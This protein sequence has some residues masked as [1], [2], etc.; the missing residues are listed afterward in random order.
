MLLDTLDIFIGLI[1]VFLILSLIVSALGDGVSAAINQKGRIFE[2]SMQVLLGNEMAARF[3]AHEAVMRLRVKGLIWLRRPS[4]VPDVVIAD[5][6]VDLCVNDDANQSQRITVNP[7]SFDHALRGMNSDV[8]CANALKEL[9]QRAGCDLDRMKLLITDW[10]NHTGDRSVSW[11][12]R[13]MGISLF[14][15]GLVAAVSLNADTLY[16]F[17]ILSED[18]ALRQSYVELATQIV[19]DAREAEV[20]ET[21]ECRQLV[22]TFLEAEDATVEAAQIATLAPACGQSANQFD[23]DDCRDTLTLWSEERQRACAAIGISGT[24]SLDALVREALPQLTPLL[25]FDLIEETMPED[26][27]DRF[28]FWFLKIIGWILTA[29]AVSIGAPFWFDLLHKLVQIRS[30]SS[31]TGT[32][33][34]EPVPAQAATTPVTAGVPRARAVIRSTNIDPISLEDLTRFDARTFGFSQLNMHWSARFSNLAYADAEDVEAALEEWGAEGG[35]LDVNNSQVIVACTPQA[36]FVSFRGTEVN[37]PD[38]AGN[39]NLTLTQPFWDAQAGF[40]V[41]AGFNQALKDVWTALNKELEDREIFSRG[42]PIWLSGHSLGGA[43]AALAALAFTHEFA[44]KRSNTIAALHTFGQPRVG[45][46]ECALALDNALP[47]RYFRSINNRDI[48]PRVPLTTMPDVLRKAKKFTEQLKYHHFRHAGHVIYFNDAGVAM[49]DPPMW[50]R[51]L[52][53][54]FVDPARA[55]EAAKQAGGDHSMT[56]YVA[57]QRAMMAMDE[58]VDAAP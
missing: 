39:A 11:Y 37:V 21:D 36:A 8:P 9:W 47:S 56:G 20:C 29:A 30:R 3:M 14:L 27:G 34:A 44:G 46:A 57:C 48:V 41:H 38:W 23:I 49:M 54:L 26:S 13:R 25:G 35:L 24:C 2:K 58:A 10:F 43:L 52:D 19:D 31:A 17:R 55:M 7:N 28:E 12:R 5:V 4:Y 45:D 50:Y 32:S 40:D 53:T 18:S 33:R 16:M 22:A 15:I 42:L 6:I 1:T 51:R